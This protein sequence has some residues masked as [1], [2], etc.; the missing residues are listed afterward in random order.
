ME[1]IALNPT[2]QRLKRNN[3]ESGSLGLRLR[4]EG[5]GLGR[6]WAANFGE[7][8]KAETLEPCEPISA[9]ATSGDE[10]CS[11]PST[12]RLESASG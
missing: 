9:P 5:I 8:K 12:S 4:D 1:A 3:S 6:V 7:V 2:P 11:S 10:C